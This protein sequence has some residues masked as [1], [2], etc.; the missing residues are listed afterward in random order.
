MPG[1]TYS[2]GSIE[3]TATLDRTEFNAALDQIK[4]DAE[5]FTRKLHTVRFDADLNLPSVAATTAKLDA[6]TRDRE[7]QIN[8]TIGAAAS[9]K[10]LAE[11]AALTGFAA[12]GGA[13]IGV[14]GGLLGLLGKAPGGPLG[15]GAIGVAVVA[16]DAA[17][18]AAIGMLG[19]LVTAFTA[20]SLAAV[21]FGA[22]A[23]EAISQALAGG[24]GM[25]P[26]LKHLRA[27]LLSAEGV[28]GAFWDKMTKMEMPIISK[29]VGQWASAATQI[30]PAF[31]PLIKAGGIGMEAFTKNLLPAFTNPAFK[32]FTGQ[33]AKAAPGVMGAGG[34]G[35]ANIGEGF[36]NLGEG[37]LPMVGVVNHGFISMTDSF[38]KWAMSLTSS[39]GFKNFIANAKKD[40]PEV[41]KVFGQIAGGVFSLIGSLVSL[42]EITA[43]A[44][45]AIV[46]WVGMVGKSIVGWYGHMTGLKQFVSRA[47]SSIAT[48]FG[49]A[50][51]F[52]SQ[53][54]GGLGRWLHT[55]WAQISADA[56]IVWNI[57]STAVKIAWEVI[58]S[59][60][61]AAL[62]VIVP[63]LQ[64]AWSVIFNATTIAWTIISTAVK[65]A[66]GVI[67]T[68]IHVISD[69]IGFLTGVWQTVTSD[70]YTAWT[71]ITTWIGGVPG[72]ILTALGNLKTLLFNIG[73]DIITGLLNGLKNA[74]KDVTSFVGG[75]GSWISSHK[76][77]IDYDRQLLVPH[78]MALMQGLAQG[79]TQGLE[80]PVTVA[81]SRATAKVTGSLGT[82]SGSVVTARVSAAS[83]GGWTEVATEVR[84]LRAEIHALPRSYKLG[85]RT[86]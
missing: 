79:L 28:F 78:G 49:K 6:E 55:H 42:G 21:A 35:L 53:I 72:K 4:A 52:I 45:G 50:A 63:I 51:G 67:V 13:G 36:A 84:A 27:Q 11:L 24:A 80:G 71:T 58:T 31:E 62:T 57:I 20:A 10:Y 43:T 2:A 81:L 86:R 12:A 65:V 40:L 29:I 34:K 33:M 25:D 14:P 15:A 70:V 46:K 48:G 75:I 19:G 54:V 73:K 76:G 64:V 39:Q 66:I 3:A 47:L 44:L 23:Y 18:P 61:H 82:G 22:V 68:A 7:V 41:A 32:Q 83:A 38:K 5:E 26:W 37:F 60:I 17:L 8:P 69:V 77:P 74:W 59:I 56:E 9:A 16:L 85:E 1:F 30:L